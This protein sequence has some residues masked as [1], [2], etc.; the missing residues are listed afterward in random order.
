[1]IVSSVPV[2]LIL[3]N[4]ELLLALSPFSSAKGLKVQCFPS[5]TSHCGALI[6]SVIFTEVIGDGWR[7]V[8]SGTVVGGKFS[9]LANTPVAASLALCHANRLMGWEGGGCAVR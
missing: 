9:F 6:S 5:I 3:F 1:M 4:T 7:H 8:L 2:T